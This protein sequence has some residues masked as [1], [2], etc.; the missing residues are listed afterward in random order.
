MSDSKE[1]DKPTLPEVVEEESKSQLEEAPVAAESEAEE[2]RAP[3]TVPAA[4]EEAEKEAGEE[5]VEVVE[6]KVYTIPIGK[7]GYAT[8][9][10]HRAPKA[11]R[12]VR[13]YVSRHMRADE[14]SIS[15]EINEAIWKRSINKPPRKIVVRAVKDKEGKVVVYPAKT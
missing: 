12:N 14:V 11:I 6:E 13:N 4:R 5:E 10:G 7:L 9:R 1:E 15:N 3:E 8:D 2:K